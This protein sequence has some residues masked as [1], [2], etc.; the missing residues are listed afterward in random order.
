[1]SEPETERLEGDHNR[2]LAGRAPMTFPANLLRFTVRRGR[3]P[4][5]KGVWFIA[6]AVVLMAVTSLYPTLYSIFMSLF[7]W[8]WGMRFDFVGLANYFSLLRDQRFWQVLFQTFYFTAG[9]VGIEL[10]LGL[11]LALV[12]DKVTW[13]SGLIRTVLMMPLMVSGIIVA[14]IWK[15]MLDPTLGIINYFLNVL[16]LPTS[17][18]F[19]GARTAMPSIILVDTW[20]Q[21]AFVFVVI[22]AGLQSLPQEPFEAARV[23]GASGWQTL[24]CITLP[25]LRPIIFIVLL[26]RTIDCLKVFAI[27]FGTTGGG[28]LTVTESVQTLAYR[29]AFKFLQMSYSMTI[30]VVFAVLILGFCL[31][32]IKLGGRT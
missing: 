2:P 4:V 7:N 25:L 30:M 8:N 11:V 15:I 17:I 28:P 1:M 5:A 24:H 22:S 27:I 32:Y 31:I 21:T 14:L 29:T 13:G 23:D 10:L 12:L 16:H 18:W 19:G 26:F 9:A 20:W 3:Q 6:P